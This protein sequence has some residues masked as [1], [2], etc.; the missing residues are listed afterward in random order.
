M[1]GSRSLEGAR[2]ASWLRA[3]AGARVVGAGARPRAP[4]VLYEFEAC[5]FCRRVREA[6]TRLDLEVTIKPCPKGGTRFRD[7]LLRLGGREQF[8]FLVDEG[9]G[10]AL[11]ESS[12]IVDHLEARYGASAGE[13]RAASSRGFF[14]TAALVASGLG[15]GAAGSRARPSR[16]PVEPLVLDGYEA[17]PESRLV[18]EVLCELEL[19]YQ[20]R[21]S[22]PGSARRGAQRERTGRGEAE[23]PRLFDPNVDSVGATF[24]GWSA[25]VDHLERTYALEPASR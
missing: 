24:E 12:D 3:G 21:P 18:R 1:S 13:Q 4:L 5:P 6:L 11:Y 23:L 14:A 22:A 9:F 19:T 2:L 25:I 7:E 17:Q 15:R 10:R 20:S 8:P 16:A